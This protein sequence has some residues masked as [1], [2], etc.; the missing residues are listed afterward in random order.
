MA[1]MREM[2]VKATGKI[3]GEHDTKLWRVLHHYVDEAR[4]KEDFS[5]V[6]K[7]GVDETSHRRGQDYVTL[8][9]DL[10]RSKVLFAT[11][12][13]DHGTVERFK[14]DLEAHG[15][16][17]GQVAEFTMD[18]S[19]AFRTGVETNFEKA[20]MTVDRYHV[21][22][23]LNQAMDE[24]R[25]AEQRRNPDL[26]G[27]R[28]S[29][30]RRSGNL[31]DGQRRELDE[32]RRRCRT[33]GRAYE[34][35]LEFEEFWDLLGGSDQADAFLA[36]WCLRVW[37]SSMPIEPVKV[38][39]DTLVKSCGMLRSTRLRS[40]NSSRIEASTRTADSPTRRYRESAIK[41]RPDT[42]NAGLPWR[43]RYRWP[44]ARR[45]RKDQHARVRPGCSPW[46]G[47]AH[48]RLPARP[49]SRLAPPAP[50]CC[51]SPARYS[52]TS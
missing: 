35:K 3:V 18:M 15:G 29:W 34:L 13:R 9:A 17:A 44:A 8:F 52:M 20:A 33:M 23:L 2:P 26:K 28:Y 16:A 19:E 22:Q 40:G 12:G 5:Q 7:V 31:S 41:Q 38:F 48:P 1:M 50:A 47:P 11:P 6:R 36:N 14:E 10:E 39:A 45:D 42:W 30:L 43:A 46:S 21:V 32:H 27:S 4:A 25:R 37:E 49:P 51:P 24:I